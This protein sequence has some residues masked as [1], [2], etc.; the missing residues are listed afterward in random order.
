[1]CKKSIY[2]ICVALVLGLMLSSAQAADPSLQGWWKFDDGAG[3]IAADSSPN[4][5]NGTLNGGAVWISGKMKGAVELDGTND[6]VELPIGSV[7]NTLTEATFA[8]W[9]NFYNSGG[10]WQRVF[11]FG[12]STN[13]N[14]FVTPAV[15][16]VGNLRFALTIA[17]NGAEDQVNA[18][19]ILPTD[20]HHLAVT[21]SGSA[22]TII[23]YLDGTEVGRN[24]NA[25][26]NV[27]SMGTTT[28]N[29][30]GRS[31]YGGDA[32]FEG[33]FDDFFIFNRIL[34]AAEVQ[35]LMK[36]YQREIASEPSPE[37]GQ[38]DVFRDV[39]LS[40]KPGIYAQTH[41]V[42]LGTDPDEVST[43][44]TGSPLLV[45]P[46]V[47]SAS[48]A[49]GRLDFSQ[50]YFWRVDEVNGPPS[51]TVFKGDLWSLTTEP[52]VY[53]IAFDNIIATA[54][55]SEPGQGPE[56][57]IDGSGLDENNLHSTTP[58]DMWLSSAGDPGSAWIQYEFD[59]PYKL[60]EMQ[61]WNYN[62]DQILYLYGIQS[63][64]IEYSTDGVTW[65]Q[66][67]ITE[68]AP[69]PGAAGYAANTTIPFDGAEV[70]YVKVSANNNFIGGTAPFNKYGLSEVKF[71]Y[72]PV[73]ARNPVPENEATGVAIDTSLNWRPGREAAQHQVYLDADQQAV[74]DGTASIGTVDQP[75]NGPLSLDLA[76]LYYWRIDEV[77]SAEAITTWPG[78][79]WS[80]TTED[81]LVVDDFESYNDIPT[82]QEGSHL[83][84]DTW[85]DGYLNP[86]ANG[87]TIGYVSGLSMETEN[88]HSG[89][90]AVPLIYDNTTAS[91]S[92]VTVDP[93]QLPIGR[94]W[95][96]GS[97]HALVIW[98]YGDPTNATSD[99]L[100]AKI[101]SAKAVFDGDISRPTWMQWI[102]DLDAIGAN[103]SSV[104]AF[105]IG[106]ERTGGSGGTGTILIDDI[107]LYGVAPEPAE[108]IFIEAES[109][110]SIQ[111][112]MIVYDDPNASG[113]KYVMKDPAAATSTGNPPDDGLVTYSFTVTGGTYTLAGRVLTVGTG[114]AFWL[115]IPGATTQT[116]NHTSGWIQWNAITVEGDWG[117]EQV[118]SSNDA[119]TVVE[120]TMPAGTYTLE[121][122]YRD[123]TSQIDAW[124]LTKID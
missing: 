5:N 80:F 40:W 54:S 95:S 30:L 36:G 87:S 67:D 100:Y 53:S 73:S 114:D 106:L 13:V 50:E 102:I 83:V 52:F 116:T 16:T 42:Y 28:N 26:N 88:V 29:W 44:D 49:P 97:P 56:K 24:T 51:N 23:M 38:T 61:V 34:T 78:S 86:A 39:T 4:G 72:I 90:Q 66:S 77:N 32:Y 124:L 99:Q 65:M 10:G 117:W 9:V 112:P 19:S 69:A 62:G 48:F 81:Y 35:A 76:T 31:Q 20:W 58:T 6:Y 79:I 91:K 98:I 63:V 2:L 33:A 94:N 37:S 11:D 27:S 115:R 43:A 22:T 8:T 121:L 17:G 107:R 64:T 120:F 15:G 71:M 18:P 96:K 110:D 3:T 12:S 21:V 1:M 84:Y 119:G 103:L 92:E 104:S 105:T 118:W 89:D 57:S 46:G 55:G 93:G 74:K 113:G 108:E 68:L 45:G 111:T 85:I 60:Y 41:N 82:G 75:V 70:K 109:Y 25:V 122:K 101:G 14:M 123:N 59:K 7:I 47:G